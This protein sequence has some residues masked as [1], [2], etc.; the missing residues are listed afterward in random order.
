VT[1]SPFVQM[2]LAGLLSDSI[3]YHPVIGC[4]VIPA[5]TPVVD[6]ATARATGQDGLSCDDYFGPSS[7]AFDLN[8]VGNHGSGGLGP[9]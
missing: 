2:I 1:I 8:A 5:V 4:E 7:I 9:A 6:R 3:P